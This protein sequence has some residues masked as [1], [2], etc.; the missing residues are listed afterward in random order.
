LTGV[1]VAAITGATR[2]RDF[3]SARVFAGVEEGE[4]MRTQIISGLSCLLIIGAGCSGSSSSQSNDGTNS[5]SE[6]ATSVVSGALNNASGTSIGQTAVPEPKSTW[7]E[8]VIDEISP[9]STA[10]AATWTC[11]GGTLS[12]IYAGPGSYAFTPV[13]CS[14]TWR[15]GKSASSNWSSTF[16]LVYGSSCDNKHGWIGN[17][18]MGCS[19]T[20]TTSA[21]GNTRTITG[22]NGGSYAIT[23]DTHGAGTSWDMSSTP[24]DNGVVATCSASGTDGCDSGTLI[25]NGSHLT[26]NLTPAGGS[27][28]KIWDHTVYTGQGGLTISRHPDRTVN[29]SVTVQH[30]LAKYNATATFNN[31]SYGEAGCCF[32][33]GGSVS[34]TFMN[35][36]D[37]GKTETLSF[38]AICGQATLTDASGLTHDIELQHCL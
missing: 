14:V 7:L 34:T 23:H 27:S 31:V 12:P 18:V 5:T 11:T 2:L 10:W 21:G 19:V 16:S 1:E 35:G 24:N 28:T 29:G 20:R 26:G 32:P 3:P 6:V 22:P 9:I 36:A 30:N 8:R 15:N 33:T 4:H 38:S 13:S 37:M 25:I 17:Q